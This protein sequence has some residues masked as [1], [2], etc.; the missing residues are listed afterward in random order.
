ML[1]KHP[2][3]LFYLQKPLKGFSQKKFSSSEP[4]DVT[5]K[6]ICFSKIRMNSFD[7]AKL[8]HGPF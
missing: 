4:E 2:S 1:N 7:P 6:E 5:Q 3:L 8:L